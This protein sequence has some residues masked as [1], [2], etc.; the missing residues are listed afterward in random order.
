MS[1]G[2]LEAG[3]RWLFTEIYNDR[4]LVRRRRHYMEIVK[5]KTAP[6][7]DSRKPMEGKMKRI[8]ALAVTSLVMGLFLIPAPAVSAPPVIAVN[9]DA[10]N[11]NLQDAVDFASG[12]TTIRFSGL[13]EED[14]TIAK[15]DITLD[16]QD[17]GTVSGTL[18]FDGAQRGVVKNATITGPGYGVVANDGASVL[19]N[20]NLIDENEATGIGVFNGAFA[21]IVDNTITDN[22]RADHFDAGIEVARAVARGQG[23]QIGNNAYAALSIYNFGTYRTGNFISPTQV[24]NDGPFEVIDVGGGDYAIDMGQ[25]AFVD[26]RQVLITGDAFV[27]R[28]SMLQIRGDNRAPNLACSQLDGSLT[29]TSIF[30]QTRLQFT[31]VTGATNGTISGGSE[32]IGNCPNL[33][34]P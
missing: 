21:R 29:G 20:D 32:L 1:V 16:G 34:L 11:A 33:P 2:A 17:L 8:A 15:D 9:C 19:I 3:L 14:V 7:P 28:Q 30:A 26:L 13:C 5:R 10:P 12:P 31:H 23:N 4:E 22:G 27:G 6:K 24:D 18:N 25:M